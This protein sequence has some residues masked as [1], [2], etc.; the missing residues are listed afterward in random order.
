MRWMVSVIF[1]GIVLS[2]CSTMPRLFQ[3]EAYIP[4][5]QLYQ[6]F[7]PSEPVIQPGDKI[8]VSIWGHDELSIGSVNNTFNANESTG[9]WLTVNADGEVNLP[10]VGRVR[11]AGLTVK[12]AGFYLEQRY[13]EYINNPVINVKV[14]NHYVT[15]LGEV[16]TPGRFQ[17]NNETPTLVEMLAQ[18]GGLGDYG[19]PTEVEVVRNIRGK[20]VTWKVDLTA[21]QGLA[22]KNITLQPGDIVYVPP[23][24]NK[25]FRESVNKA[26]PIVSILTSLA[27]VISVLAR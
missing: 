24:P 17:L 7:K 9:N 18:A 11:L 15:V 5:A 19:D 25:Q 20:T 16:N 3:S 21:V 14:L 2:G 10:K 8:T 22:T 23:H 27:V 6:Y 1:L 12:E 26:T 4:T 13:T